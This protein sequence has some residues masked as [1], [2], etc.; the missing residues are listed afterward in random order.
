MSVFDREG[1]LALQ[2]T[3]FL[4]ASWSVLDVGSGNGRLASRIAST[5]GAKVTLCDV[6]PRSVPGMSYLTM[7]GPAALPC[8][9]GSCDAVMMLFMLHHMS[10]F[11]QQERLLR[12]AA[13][14]AR[15]R[16]ILLEDTAVGHMERAF[17]M[18]WDFVLNAPSGV[19]TPFTFRTT[20]EWE[21]VVKR[22]GFQI[23]Q[24]RTFRSTWPILRSY[25][26]SIVVANVPDGVDRRRAS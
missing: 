6:T 22:S 12:D 21:T 9:D 4:D 7:S 20:A 11:E 1:E 23:F 8:P 5:S 15:K 13:R 3:P 16:L 24:V 14:V 10:T 18:A 26:Q 25:T 17:N 19:P 2:V